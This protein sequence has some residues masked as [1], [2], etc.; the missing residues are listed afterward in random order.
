MRQSSKVIRRGSSEARSKDAAEARGEGSG[1]INVRA[2]RVGEHVGV[3]FM[4]GLIPQPEI[5]PEGRG[6]PIPQ[7]DLG[8][9]AKGSKT[10]NNILPNGSV[11]VMAV[12]QV[13]GAI[14]AVHPAKPGCPRGRGVGVKFG[15]KFSEKS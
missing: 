10:G 6:G 13:V 5:H 1:D 2:S 14:P 11:K 12:P 8:D 4:Q 15:E 9:R 3:A 7:G